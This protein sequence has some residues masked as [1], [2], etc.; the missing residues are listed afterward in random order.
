MNFEIKEAVREG[1][2]AKMVIAG[3]SG[4]GKT[5][6]ALQLAKGLTRN[7]K[8][9]VLDS[10]RGSAKKY[11]KILGDL[12]YSVLDL[13]GFSPETY[14]GAI[15]YAVEKG[16][17]TIIV[18]SMSHSW[19]GKGGALELVDMAA[20]RSHS[21][22]SFVA[23]RD[24]NPLLAEFTDVLLSV[25][26]HVIATVRTKQEYVIVE[27]EKGKK[28][29]K[30]LGMAPV[31]RDGFEYEFDI[32]ARIDME[33]NLIIDK[34][35]V[36][37][38]HDGVYKKAGFELGRQLRT[39]YDGGEPIVTVPE[40]YR[41]DNDPISPGDNSQDT[42]S[43]API[44]VPPKLQRI[45]GLMTR[46]GVALPEITELYGKNPREMSEDEKDAVI[47]WLEVK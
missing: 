36:E 12:K 38:I 1:Q 33:N 4:G 23:W 45:G 18:D 43:V 20:R 14:S 10:E 41:I 39:W 44:P 29:P 17:D 6:T 21:G 37:F 19:A 40:P 32:S 35:R 3:P 15:K 30:K 46:K 28:E 25:P 34:T 5:F 13:P 16:F 9:V 7:G 31:I 11:A 8:I 47:A 2:W 27:N 26:A 42:V 24:V 22:N